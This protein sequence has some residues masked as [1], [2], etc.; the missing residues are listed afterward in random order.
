MDLYRVR[1]RE[2]FEGGG[3]AHRGKGRLFSAFSTVFLLRRSGRYFY[4]QSFVAK[5][6]N[7]RRSFERDVYFQKLRHSLIRLLGIESENQWHPGGKGKK[8]KKR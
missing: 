8:K 6:L 5:F 4:E 1:P 7:G 3:G 2:H